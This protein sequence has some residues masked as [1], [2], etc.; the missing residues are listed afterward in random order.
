MANEK[1]VFR[2]A[3]RIYD[4]CATSQENG[5]MA[6]DGGGLAEA[7]NDLLDRAQTEFPDNEIVQSL[8]EVHPS[9]DII[10]KSTA[11]QQVKSKTSSL[12]AAIGID[13][14]DLETQQNDELQPITI[15]VDQAVD[16]AQDMEQSPDISQSQD[17]EADQQQTQ[18]QQ[19]YVDIEIILEDIG[20]ETLPPDEKEDLREIVREYEQ[21]LEGDR[22]SSRLQELLAR[23]KQY[24]SSVTS[25]LGILGLQY[26][27]TGILPE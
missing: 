26:G 5:T 15:S 1:Y 23:A 17:Q 22:D 7:Y 9:G 19:Q 13:V 10:Q 25:K 12:A 3:K 6:S 21:E 20:R 11:V 27:V 16:Q 24:S 14:G 8:D 2:Q 18:K 4:N